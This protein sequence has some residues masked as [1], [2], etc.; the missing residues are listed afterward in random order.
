MES[1]EYKQIKAD[2]ARFE[3]DRLRFLI[4]AGRLIFFCFLISFL[5]NMAR[6]FIL[7]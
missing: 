5:A 2:M 1:D 4:V 7:R 6:I 3:R